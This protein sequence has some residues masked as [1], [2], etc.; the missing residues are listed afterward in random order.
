M[1]GGIDQ[2]FN[3]NIANEASPTSSASMITSKV[4][5]VCSGWKILS[6]IIETAVEFTMQVMVMARCILIKVEQQ[7][8]DD[9]RRSR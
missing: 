3:H 9:R 1:G 5:F 8:P 6:S 4:I 2:N 7:N